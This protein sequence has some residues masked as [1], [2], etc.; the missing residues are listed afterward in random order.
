MSEV[1]KPVFEDRP[2]A[3]QLQVDTGCS[4]KGE[5]LVSMR[6]VIFH[7][8]GEYDDFIQLQEAKLPENAA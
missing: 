4:E 6:N 1:V 2:L 3:Q 8:C 7:L 5:D